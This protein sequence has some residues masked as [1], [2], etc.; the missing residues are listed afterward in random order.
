MTDTSE[1]RRA[2]VLRAF[3]RSIDA[4]SGTMQQPADP[5]LL[6]TLQRAMEALPR[7]TRE[8][9]LA[10]CIDGTNYAEIARATGLSQRQVEREMAKALYHLS[11]FLGGDERTPQRRLRDR[12]KRRWLR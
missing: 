12:Q 6:A 11:C 1:E 2:R 9:F 7:R 8:I 10:N 4:G 3:D 5:E